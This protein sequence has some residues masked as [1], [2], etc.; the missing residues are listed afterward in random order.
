MVYSSNV[1][2]TVCRDIWVQQHHILRPFSIP[3]GIAISKRIEKWRTMPFI[4]SFEWK[5]TLSCLNHRDLAFLHDSYTTMKTTKEMRILVQAST[6][7][8]VRRVS[9]SNIV[10]REF[11]VFSKWNVELILLIFSILLN[12]GKHKEKFLVVVL[13]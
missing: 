12:K 13:S 10:A 1:C 7:H 3:R 4:S 5:S 8:I 2:K 11:G 6:I 9:H